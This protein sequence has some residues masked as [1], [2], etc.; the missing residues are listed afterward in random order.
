MGV[1]LY[2][3][4]LRVQTTRWIVTVKKALGPNST[5]APQNPNPQVLFWLRH[6]KVTTQNVHF[7]V[8]L[9]RLQYNSLRLEWAGI[10]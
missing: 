8:R 3:S 7:K 5:Q 9:D 1:D 4:G 10:C 6:F 2:M